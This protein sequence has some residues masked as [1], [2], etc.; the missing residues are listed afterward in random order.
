MYYE[1]GEG[2][3][4]IYIDP[5]KRNLTYQDP[6]AE[7]TEETEKY[8]YMMMVTCID[9][10]TLYRDKRGEAIK[11]ID[12]YTQ[13]AH[14]HLITIYKW[15]YIKDKVI[16]VETEAPLNATTFNLSHN[17]SNHN[18]FGV[19][20]VKNWKNYSKSQFTNECLV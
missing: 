15:W 20:F 17:T 4:S 2:E 5:C 7:Y 12:L 1:K 10:E 3:I 16:F 14:P 11:I 18:Q 19:E 8:A 9:I 13:L 6:N